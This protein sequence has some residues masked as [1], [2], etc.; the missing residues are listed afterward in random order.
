MNVQLHPWSSVRKLNCPVKES[1]CTIVAMKGSELAAFVYSD[2]LT[3]DPPAEE[4]Q[5]NI[6]RSIRKLVLDYFCLISD[7]TI[8][9]ISLRS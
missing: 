9:V 8:P 4:L 7:N 5:Q 6:H 2:I 3:T 1:Q